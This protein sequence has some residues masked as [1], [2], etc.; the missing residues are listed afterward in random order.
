MAFLV[1]SRIAIKILGTNFEEN[2]EAGDIYFQLNLAHI[3][4]PV[5]NAL[6]LVCNNRE[7][8]VLEKMFDTISIF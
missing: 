7:S 2:P 3:L 1:A 8:Y 6:S 4:V 5:F